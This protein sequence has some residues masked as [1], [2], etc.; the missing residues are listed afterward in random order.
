MKVLLSAFAC[1]PR[2]GSRPNIGWNV[3]RQV[4]GQRQV[5][6]LTSP[7]NR[8]LI[9]QALVAQEVP[10]VCFVYVDVHRS[11]QSTGGR[12]WSITCTMLPG[13]DLLCE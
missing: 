2:R 9:E 4:A 12:R 6:V 5:W 3:V 11:L 1:A 13:G 10:D 7:R 8:P